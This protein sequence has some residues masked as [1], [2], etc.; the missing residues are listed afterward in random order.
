MTQNR[1]ALVSPK[2]RRE[3][4]DVSAGTWLIAMLIGQWAFFYYL[5]AFYGTTL[6]SGDW[7]AWNRLAAFGRKPYVPG[8]GIGNLAFAGHALG[9]GII[10]LGGALQLIPQLRARFPRFHRWNGRVFLATVTLLS[11]SGFYLVWVRGT[12][13]TSLDALATTLNGVLILGF[14]AAAY[15][16]IRR[17][18]LVSHRRWAMRLYLVSNG[19]WFLRVGIFAYLMLGNAAGQNPAFGDPFFHFWKF[20]CL[21]VPLLLLELYLRARRGPRP[22]RIATALTLFAATAAM[23]VGTAVFAVICQKLISGAPLAL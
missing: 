23:A 3:L 14:A 20:G 22:A 11:L 13:P 4:L 2:P 12:S 21:L 19:Q 18:D 17:R 10:A 7:E 9:A 16:A 15:L 6:L 1:Q 5:T 8:D